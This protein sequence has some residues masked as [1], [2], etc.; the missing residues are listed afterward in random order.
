MSGCNGLLSPRKSCALLRIESARGVERSDGLD[1]G[2]AALG[3]RR[4]DFHHGRLATSHC[5]ALSITG[6]CSF[7]M[8]FK[9]KFRDRLG[10][11]NGFIAASR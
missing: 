6:R 3:S 4:E 1:G 5:R 9:L 10:R 2:T 11:K 7:A 8:G